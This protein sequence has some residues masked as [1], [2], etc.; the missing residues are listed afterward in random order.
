MYKDLER[1][2]WRP[3][4][5]KEI[6]EHVARCA[7]CQM[8]KIEHQKPGGTLQPLD[9]PVWKWEHVSMDFVTGLPMTRRKNDTVW[10]I[11]DRFTKSTHFLPMRVN[12]PLQQLA[13]LYM[14]KIVRL[15]G[16]PMSIVSNRDTRFTSRFWRA[17]HEAF[18]TVLNYSTAFQPQTDGQTE[19]TIQTMERILRACALDHGGS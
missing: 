7:T 2:F 16:V 1:N 9:I 3:G 13:E 12:L 11:V 19:R 14:S 18:G 4:M 5:K 6:T 8:V 17:L 10:V 15:H